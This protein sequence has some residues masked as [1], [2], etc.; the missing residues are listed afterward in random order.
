MVDLKLDS[1]SARKAE[2]FVLKEVSLTQTAGQLTAII[3]PNGA[4]KTSLLEA[5]LGLLPI[6]AG[7]VCI[8]SQPVKEVP[9]TDLAKLIAYLPQARPLAWP[10]RVIDTVAM[11]RFAWGGTMGRLSLDDAE[12]INDA[13]AKCEIQHLKDRP[14]DQLSGGELARIHCARVFAAQTP[15]MLA[16]EPVTAL[17]PKHQLKIMSLIQN[18]V[19]EGNSALVIMHDISLAA[20]FSDRLIWMKEGKI[21]ADGPPAKTVTETQI[22]TIFGI[23]AQ[24][25]W[26]DKIPLI[27]TRSL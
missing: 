10:L 9:H 17:D 20:R 26:R 15:I 4:G 19:R 2:Q 21:M 5:I 14:T 18:Y 13:L 22:E 24:V 25:Q 8:D 11:G 7:S 23:G 1:V 27:I 3:G 12:I 16:D 6:A